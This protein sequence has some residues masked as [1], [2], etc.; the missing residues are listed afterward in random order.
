MGACL[1][2][3]IALYAVGVGALG[4]LLVFSASDWYSIDAA[5]GA[6]ARQQLGG[7]IMWIPGGT[8]YLLAALAAV[9][10]LLAPAASHERVQL[11]GA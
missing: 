8:V 5:P 2:A 10:R 3:A 7:L 6:L 1:V 11:S 9:H 4:A